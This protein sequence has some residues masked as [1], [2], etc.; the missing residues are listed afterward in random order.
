MKNISII[1]L[2]AVIMFAVTGGSLVGPILPEMMAPLG[3]GQKSI[4]LIL[5]VYTLLALIS[6]PLSGLL[7]DLYGRKAV[8]VP[9][10]I[11]FGFSGLLITFTHDFGLILV[12]RGLQG[13]GV[14]GMMNTVTTA[15]GD[16]YQGTRRH[17]IMGYRFTVQ[18]LTNAAI[19]FVSGAL[20][21]MAWFLPFYIHSLAI[22]LGIFAAFKL[23][24]PSGKSP[25]PEN[26]FRRALA[27]MGNIRAIWLFSS[28]FMGFLLLYCL[29]VYMPIFVV[30]DLGL[31]AMHAGLALSVGS[32]TAS[33]T[34]T[35]AGMLRKR[36]P[37]E[38]L[39]FS[40]FLVCAIALLLI[41]T[42]PGYWLMLAFFVLWG[43]GYGTIMPVLNASAAGLVSA[44]LRGGVLSIFTMLIYL[45]QTLSPPFFALFVTETGVHRTFLAAAA[46][47]L[48]PIGFTLFIGFKKKTP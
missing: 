14:G 15:I 39:I 22:F 11:L 42:A 17:Q 32:G 27:A 26:Y 35:R 44:E 45:G 28:N 20:A 36:F 46:L 3:V 12:L 41:G 1:I 30:G 16:M 5:S 40:G 10:T 18:G 25:R 4:G 2:L 48:L 23:K 21:V 37:E 33:L 31:T 29:V 9:C 8:I 13:I 47:A 24:E 38:G 43:V 34:A 6:T 19:P 7:A